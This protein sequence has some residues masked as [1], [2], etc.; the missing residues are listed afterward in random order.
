[1]LLD[2]T[3]SDWC[4]ACILLNKEVFSQDAFKK[5]SSENFVLVELDFPQ[6]KEQSAELKE[7]N[8]KLSEK[9]AISNFPTIFLA[10]AQ[11]RPYAKTGYLE[12]GA[13]NYVKHL[14]S[15]RDI[16]IQRDEFL[17]AADK[18]S[19]VAKAKLLLK[20]INVIDEEIH[21]FYKEIADQITTLDPKDETGYAKA[22]KTK[23]L[24]LQLDQELMALLQQKK[25]DDA[26]A[27][28]Q[29]FLKTNELDAQSKQKV[30]FMQ[31]YCYSPNSIANVDAVDKILDKVIAIDPNTKIAQ[32]SKIIKERIV[33]MRANLSQKG[34]ENS[35]A[36]ND[37][38]CSSCKSCK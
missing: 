35:K 32:R 20:A 7:Q 8:Q 10:D 16:R 3:G 29:E 18:A 9:F 12:G 4:E 5:Y 38:N 28:V 24:I 17:A 21:S 11:G 6:N 37:K 36:K 30:T 25:T 27:K 15:L 26:L 31:I 1:M 13:D 23:A 14:K 19:G 22:L 2:F 33:G 34:G